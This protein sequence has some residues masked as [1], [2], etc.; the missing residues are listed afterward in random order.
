M[1]EKKKVKPKFI[2]NR[3]SKFIEGYDSENYDYLGEDYE[4]EE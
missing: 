3:G 1:N 4:E 2:D